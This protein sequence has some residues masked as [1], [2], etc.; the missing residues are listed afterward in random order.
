MGSIEYLMKQA[1]V[2][3]LLLAAGSQ[4]GC[5]RAASSRQERSS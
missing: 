4:R 5:D 1:L 3:G 2:G